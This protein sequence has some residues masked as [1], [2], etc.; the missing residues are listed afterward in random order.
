MDLILIGD[1]MDYAITGRS[2]G[3]ENSEGGLWKI[4]RENFNTLLAEILRVIHRCSDDVQQTVKNT[5]LDIK[6]MLAC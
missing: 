3:K 1:H 2:D 4:T 5:K 6:E